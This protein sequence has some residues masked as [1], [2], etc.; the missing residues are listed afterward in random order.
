MCMMLIK[1]S[2]GSKNATNEGRKIFSRKELNCISIEDHSQVMKVSQYKLDRKVIKARDSTSTF[3]IL[4]ILHAS[5]YRVCCVAQ[6][7]SA[8]T[9]VMNAIYNAYEVLSRF[10]RFSS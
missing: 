2:G 3:T 8:V 10:Y 5:N 7:C 6:Y 9:H 4:Y 1:P